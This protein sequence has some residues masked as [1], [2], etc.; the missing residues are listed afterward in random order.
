MY[1][2]REAFSPTRCREA[3][4][5]PIREAGGEKKSHKG[6]GRCTPCVPSLKKNIRRHIETLYGRAIHAFFYKKVV[7]KK[8][9]LD[10]PK[11]EKKIKKVL[12][13]A[14]KT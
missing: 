8:V 1:E 10:W 5:L 14:S 4:I 9:V 3:L 12:V 2:I 11:P 6:G 7:Y 13:L